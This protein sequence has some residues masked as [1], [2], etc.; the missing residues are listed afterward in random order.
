MAG[1]TYRRPDPFRSR[2]FRFTILVESPI[3]LP[4]YKGAVFRGSF[5]AIFRRSVCAAICGQCADCTVARQ[6]LYVAL[7]ETPPPPDYA[8]AAKFSQAPRP[9]VLNPPLTD[10][11]E[12]RPG[13]E[14]TF[15]LVLVGPAVEALPYFIHTFSELGRMGLGR[16]RGQ[17]RLANVALVG[18]LGVA[19][20]YDGRTRT[21]S[22][23]PLEDEADTP[24]FQCP[25]ANRVTLD[26]LTPLRL[27][28]DGKLVAR[29]DFP[30]F[31]E[32]L[33]HRVRLLAAFYGQNGSMPDAS[34]FS[35]LPDLLERSNEV[36]TTENHLHWYD[37]ERYSSRQQTTMNFGG[38]KGRITFAG[39]LAPFLPWLRLGERVNVG[40]STTFGLGRYQM[41]APTA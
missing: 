3:L 32:R 39:D 41:T 19:K 38:L 4:P 30:F 35:S 21:L 5:G 29:L 16:G 17:F 24:V 22:V 12:F 14:L 27:K 40:Q 18:A 13:E 10:R 20:I 36:R 26:F 1:F 28:R 37:W 8:D 31:F 7:F 2:E 15:H 34:D 25:D 33:T 23:S 6:C 9:Y 11:R